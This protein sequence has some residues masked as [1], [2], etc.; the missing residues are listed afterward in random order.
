MKYKLSFLFLSFMLLF[1]NSTYA[2]FT[3]Q[4]DSLGLVVIPAEKYDSY[5]PGLG[6][7]AGDTFTLEDSLAGFYGKG[8]MR[9][10]MAKGDGNLSNADTI[11]IRLSYNVDFVKTGTYYV[12]ARAYFHDGKSDSF[13]WGFDSTAVAQI[14]RGSS[15]VYD[16]W[17]W[18]KADSSFFVSTAIHGIG[19]RQTRL[20]LL[21]LQACVPLIFLVVNR[22]HA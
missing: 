17:H 13:I 5:R 16:S 9:A 3:Q 14:Q 1:F 19:I 8:Y 4:S 12:W 20:S 21:V 15:Y 11:G 2:R 7:K 22:R 18:Y 10:N 6:T